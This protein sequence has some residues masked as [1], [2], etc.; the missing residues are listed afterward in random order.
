MKNKVKTYLEDLTSE[1]I[2]IIIGS[3]LGDGCITIY[4]I[5]SGRTWSWV[6]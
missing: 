1:Q 6:N 3:L 5:K 4:D 2:E